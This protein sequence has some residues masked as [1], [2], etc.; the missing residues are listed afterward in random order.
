VAR[1]SQAP[2][3]LPDSEP[4]QI[5]GQGDLRTTM[6]MSTNKMVHGFSVLEPLQQC[7]KTV[8]LV[9]QMEHNL[10]NHQQGISTG[11][12]KNTWLSHSI[13]EQGQDLRFRPISPEIVCS[14]TS[15]RLSRVQM[16]SHP[17]RLSLLIK[18]DICKSQI[19][20]K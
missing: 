8:G 16:G 19:Q 6:K 10:M 18:A 5:K 3:Q 7:R 9:I 17:T 20:T 2:C 14:L 11:F 15:M 12:G 13:L 4:K 1:S